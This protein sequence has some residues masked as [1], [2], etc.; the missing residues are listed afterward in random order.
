MTI[1]ERLFFLPSLDQLAPVFAIPGITWISL[2]YGRAE[3]EVDRLYQR[4]GH[5]LHIPQGLDLTNDIGD[6]AALVAALDAVAGTTSAV[7][8]LA[9][10]LGQPALVYMYYPGY[11]E[12]RMMGQEHVP[13]LPT[14]ETIVYGAGKDLNDLS[15]EFADLLARYV[16]RFQFK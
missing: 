3:D 8:I 5:R 10:A 2:Q 13:W 14:M 7:A 4:T 16:A 11:N 6:V 12:N 1:D 15:A 9:G